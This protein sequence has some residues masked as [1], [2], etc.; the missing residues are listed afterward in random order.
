MHEVAT[1]NHKLHAK[2]QQLQQ[3]VTSLS[4]QM[5]E[6]E[7]LLDDARQQYV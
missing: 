7:K 3:Q 5:A 6:F 4:S 1:E 2:R